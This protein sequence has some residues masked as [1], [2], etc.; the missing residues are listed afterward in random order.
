MAER[1]AEILAFLERHGLEAAT[2]RPLAG[3]ASARRYERIVAAQ[4]A[5]LMDC[6]PEQLDVRPFL[7]VQAALAA[8]GVSVPQVHAA[9]PARGLVLLEDFG[10]TS[11]SQ[12]LIAGAEPDAL[13]G[14]AVDLLV[15]LQRRA[16]VAGLPA[17]DDARF[18]A[19]LELLLSFATPGVP[20]AAAAEYRS[21]WQDR[22][23]S[24][25]VGE[26]CFVYVDY[27]ADNLHWLEDRP[28][29]RR[30]GL[31][32][33][34]DARAGPPAYDLVSLLEDARRDVPR[35]LTARMIDRYLGHRPELDRDAFMASFAILGAQRN[36]K[37]L[38]LFRRLAETGKPR[39]LELLPRV[40][41]HL[42]GDLAH[43]ALADLRPWYDRYLFDA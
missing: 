4:P 39:Y 29:H 9:D 10:E 32:D 23:G 38:G 19:E 2:R 8:L 35:E 20:A 36:S 5:V 40:E 22:L 11:F 37:I 24:A 34:Q 7:H 28:G 16:P 25:R 43:P 33:F 13:Y 31:L 42:R 27:H 1:P 21:L 17:Y 3:D 14:A 26:R 12:A 6:P 30:V 18:M 41:A 15:D